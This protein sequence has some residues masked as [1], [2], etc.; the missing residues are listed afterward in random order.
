MD[1]LDYWHYSDVKVLLP[2]Q[3]FAWLVAT[4]EIGIRARVPATRVCYCG[5]Q[6]YQIPPV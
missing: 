5:A 4:L 2:P 6:T 1:K 3:W